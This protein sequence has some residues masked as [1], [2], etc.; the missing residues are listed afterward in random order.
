MCVCVCAC[1]CAC[2]RACVHFLKIHYNI[3][4]SRHTLAQSDK[5]VIIK[6]EAETQPLLFTTGFVL[7]WL[8]QVH[9]KSS[10]NDIGL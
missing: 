5:A 7:T 1:V 8:K 3:L 2:V 10:V 4:I 9:L 6:Y